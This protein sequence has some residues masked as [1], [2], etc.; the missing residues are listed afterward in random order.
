[1]KQSSQSSGQLLY[2]AIIWPVYKLF[3]RDREIFNIDNADRRAGL[4]SL[5]NTLHVVYAVHH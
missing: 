5:V 3:Q 4:D 2:K 1:M